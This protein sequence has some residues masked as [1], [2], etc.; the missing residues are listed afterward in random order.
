MKFLHISDL[1]FHRDP[2]DNRSADALLAAIHQQYPNHTLIV[3]G[4][5]SDDGTEWQFENAL[6]ALIPFK[7]R[8]FI[9]PGNHDFGAMGNFYSEERA[10][11]FDQMLSVPLQQGGTFTGDSSP[12]VNFVSDN[13]DTVMLIALDTN[14]ETCDPF[15]FACGELGTAQLAALNTILRDPSNAQYTKVVFFHHHLFIHDDPFMEL[16][17]GQELKRALYGKV[18]VV[19]F[20]HKHAAGKWHSAGGAQ[21][22]LASDS[23][24]ESQRAREIEIKGKQVA[25]TDVSLKPGVKRRAGR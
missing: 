9:A 3:T 17:D 19:L 5:V 2:Q 18:D 24:P 15:D 8:V 20:G 21:L 14:L 1:H 16:R 11:R 13:T 10:R 4:D 7:G 25:T 12:V 22:I 6:K 23:S